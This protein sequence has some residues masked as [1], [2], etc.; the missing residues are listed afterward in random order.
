MSADERDTTS[1]AG[2]FAE[3]LG[4]LEDATYWIHQVSVQFPEG[5]DEE[6]DNPFWGDVEEAEEALEGILAD[7]KAVE[8]HMPKEG[9]AMLQ[10]LVEAIGRHPAAEADPEVIDAINAVE[11]AIRKNDE[12]I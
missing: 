3:A 10:G 2:K 11:D 6:W 1:I 9:A 7:L 5:D 8:T 4:C 12:V